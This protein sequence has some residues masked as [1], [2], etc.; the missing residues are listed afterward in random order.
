MKY[1]LDCGTHLFQGLKEF[2]KIYKFD[3]S[4]KIYSFEANPI[5]YKQSKEFLSDGL[6]NLDIIHQNLAV[7]NEDSEIQINCQILPDSAN[8][9]GSNILK[10]PPNRDIAGGYDFK[11]HTERVKC[12]DLSSFI[13]DLKDV[14]VL[15]L[16][17]DIEGAEFQ[18]LEKIINDKSYEK[19]NEMYVE[20][21]ERF[22]IN[23]I[24]KYTNL[25]NNYIN[26]FNNNNIKIT[27]WF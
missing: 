3:N 26:F 5:T 16:K 15:I 4:W 14:E 10:D 8:G 22:F 24:Q 6:E 19:I 1:F 18:V 23:E 21:H 11:W 20:F 7:S 25:K 27:T 12:F 2:N 13:K 9:Q 17:L